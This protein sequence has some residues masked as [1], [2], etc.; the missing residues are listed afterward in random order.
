MDGI[1]ANMKVF[2]KQLEDTQQKREIILDSLKQSLKGS[3]LQSEVE[4]SFVDSEADYSNSSFLNRSQQ[5]QQNSKYKFTRSSTVNPTISRKAFKSPSH[6]VRGSSFLDGD[7]SLRK[8]VTFSLFQKSIAASG[9]L[10]P[11]K[12]KLSEHNSHSQKKESSSSRKKSPIPFRKS[13]K[14]HK[15]L[16]S[17]TSLTSFGPQ[18]DLKFLGIRN[19]KLTKKELD[20]IEAK[21][22]FAIETMGEEDY[23]RFGSPNAL[24]YQA[25]FLNRKGSEYNEKNMDEFYDKLISTYANAPTVQQNVKGKEEPLFTYEKYTSV[26]KNIQK[27]KEELE[28]DKFAEFFKRKFEVNSFDLTEE[29]EPI[30]N[31]KM[32]KKKLTQIKH[33]ST[34]RFAQSTYKPKNPKS[35]I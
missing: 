21:E 5:M 4:E 29:G 13:H 3:L 33:L 19:V 28:N 34:K 25:Q 22:K 31:Y 14:K 7:N 32:L 11:E 17:T 16:Q 1:I 18:I 20:E 12:E 15:K 23:R 2:Q 6:T 10:N 30:C 9:D 8:K 27:V 24:L 35:I 26:G